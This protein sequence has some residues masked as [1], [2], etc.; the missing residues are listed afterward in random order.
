VKEK[1]KMDAPPGRYRVEEK[2]GRLIVVDTQSGTPVTP[3]APPGPAGMQRAAAAAPASSSLAS[4]GVALDKAGAVLVGMAAEGWDAEGRAIIAWNWQR[5][6]GRPQRWDALLDAGQQRRLG[7]ALL[8]CCA[9]PLAA[10]T[11]LLGDNFAD[12]F[13]VLMLAIAPVGWGGLALATLYRET[14]GTHAPH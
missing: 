1:A 6:G 13:L 8:A 7:R 10:A 9:L 4:A 12:T 3:P 14:N 5:K 11:I 2:A